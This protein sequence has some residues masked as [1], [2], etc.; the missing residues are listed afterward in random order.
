[1]VGGASQDVAHTWPRQTDRRGP[2]REDGRGGWVGGSARAGQGLR[3][4]LNPSLEIKEKA[5]G[6]IWGWR[7][8]AESWGLGVG[9][10]LRLL[11]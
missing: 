11:F 3:S 4:L 9:V 1:M 8:E 2:R 6:R 5:G 7:A 10:G